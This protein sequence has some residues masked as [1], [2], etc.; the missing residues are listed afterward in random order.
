MPAMMHMMSHTQIL[1]QDTTGDRDIHDEGLA[2]PRAASPSHALT[3]QPPT[4]CRYPRLVIHNH[5]R[6]PPVH[7]Q[8]SCHSS[9]A[10][11][12]SPSHCRHSCSVQDMAVL[13]PR[14]SKPLPC[15]DEERG[16]SA[17]AR[18]YCGEHPERCTS[19][20]PGPPP[21]LTY[22]HRHC[23][24]GTSLALH[25]AADQGSSWEI[26]C[27]VG[28]YPLTRSQERL[29]RTQQVCQLSSFTPNQT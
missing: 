3:T 20:P 7:I 5:H 16:R 1:Y 9:F 8:P 11:I 19:P 29:C 21:V 26:H 2:C 13:L 27:P 10:L 24:S 18:S 23:S 15:Q 4:H 22:P 14:R 6:H 25:R 12:R 17:R 28:K